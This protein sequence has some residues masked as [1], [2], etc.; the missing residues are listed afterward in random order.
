MSARA[1]QQYQRLSDEDVWDVLHLFQEE[2]D[3]F[4]RY[5]RGYPEDLQYTVCG[6][7][8]IDAIIRVD[9]RQ[10]YFSVFHGMDINDCKKAALFAYWIV[11]FRPIRITD[12]RYLNRLGNDVNELFAIHWLLSVLTAE[13][14]IQ[15]WNGSTGVDITFDHPYIEKLRYSFRFRNLTIDSMIVLADTITTGTFQQVKASEW[16]LHIRISRVYRYSSPCMPIV[17]G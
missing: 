6:L 5:V 4:I 17:V 8:L 11:K 1:S 13:G 3:H 16:S 10:V 2:I 7:D 12:P 9:K 15:V 14:K